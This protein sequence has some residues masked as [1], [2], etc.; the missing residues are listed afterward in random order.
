[1]KQKRVLIVDDDP[2]V[3]TVV[4]AWLAV[5]GHDVLSHSTPFGTAQVV[6]ATNPDIILLD[7]LM[8]GLPG[9]AVALAVRKLNQG[10]D[11]KIIFFSGSTPERLAAL[12]NEYGAA[13]YIEKTGDRVAF[14]ENFNRIALEQTVVVPLMKE[15]R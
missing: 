1:M 11:L 10:K 13:G 14:L 9:E 8:P 5:D 15:E 6:R 3:I 12:A 7:V 2:V 4:Q